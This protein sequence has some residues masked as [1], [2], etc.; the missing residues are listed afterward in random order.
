MSQLTIMGNQ[1]INK[2]LS[3]LSFLP[4]MGNQ[5]TILIITATVLLV[6]LCKPVTQQ[7]QLIIYLHY[8]RLF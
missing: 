4:I 5:N 2:V 8:S 3:Q 7:Y 6:T 1:Y